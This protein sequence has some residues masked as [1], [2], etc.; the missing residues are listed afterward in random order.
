MGTKKDMRF[1]V[2]HADNALELLL[3][4]LARMNEI[5]L[6]DKKGRPVGYYECIDK[7]EERGVKLQGLPDI[8]ILHTERNAIYHLGN[9]PD[10]EKADWLVYDVALSLISRICV[11]KLD[12]DIKRYSDSFDLSQDIKNEIELTRSKITN[13]YLFEA[14]AA[15][16]AR[17]FNASIVSSYTAIEVFLREGI[18]LDLR[19]ETVSLESLVKDELLIEE[20]AQYILLLRNIRNRILHEGY[21]ATNKEAEVALEMS[22]RIIGGIED[23]LM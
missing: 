5:R 20:D 8:D 10:K 9:Q 17:M 11:E 16:N 2:L 3:K 19:K 15:F 12:F 21:L 7:L 4:E 14:H 23:V 1:A 6:M 18:P 13:G 22:R